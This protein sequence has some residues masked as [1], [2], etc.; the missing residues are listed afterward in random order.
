MADSNK[1]TSVK[2]L[3]T[4][5]TTTTTT[6]QPTF[7]QQTLDGVAVPQGV[8]LPPPE[9]RSVVEKTA[10]YVAR[11]GR[12]FEERIRENEKA[13]VKFSFIKEDDPYFPYYSWRVS[14]LE[15]GGPSIGGNPDDANGTKAASN[16]NTEDKKIW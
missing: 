6:P 15:E 9:V 2:E 16:G 4:T 10:A 5:T 1:D 7:S 13:N 8:I 11:N 12:G 14:G 3:S